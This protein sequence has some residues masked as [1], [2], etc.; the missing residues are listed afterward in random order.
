MVTTVAN[1]SEIRNSV[2]FIMNY[3]NYINGFQSEKKLDGHLLQ[4]TSFIKHTD[5][6]PNSFSYSS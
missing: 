3:I 2:Y 5:T 6:V 4:V 1:C